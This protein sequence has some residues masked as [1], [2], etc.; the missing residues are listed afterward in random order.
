MTASLAPRPLAALVA[1][2]D[3]LAHDGVSWLLAGSA[4]RALLGYDV[5]P[6]DIDIEVAPGDAE[7][8]SRRLGAPLVTAEGAGRV[9]RRATLWIAGIEVDVTCGLEVTGPTHRLPP[10][11]ALQRE[12]SHELTVCGRPVRVA[13]VEETIARAVVLDDGRR[14]AT[15]A[16]QVTGAAVPARPD[17][18]ELRLSSAIERA[19][20]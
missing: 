19:A 8:A 9:S 16:A 7:T 4:G 5:R 3:R 15:I 11:F 6:R 14:L 12:W 18:V 13:P 10:D 2:A 17:Y 1:L 20:R